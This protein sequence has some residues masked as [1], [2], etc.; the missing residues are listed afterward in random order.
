MKNNVAL[1]ALCSALVGVMC[2]SVNA[3]TPQ[4]K[5]DFNQSGR[6]ESGINEPGY[7]AWPIESA[8]SISK[9]LSGVTITLSKQGSNGSGLKSDWY[10]A[11]TEA[12]YYARLASDGVTVDGGEA[13]AAILMSFSGLPNGTHSLLLTLNTVASPTTNTFAP[14]DISVNGTQIINNLVPS[15]RATSNSAAKTA[16]I[17]FS[18]SNGKADILVKADTGTSASN[19]NVIINGF[20]LN[21]PD[22]TKQTA[23]PIP[24]D[25]DQHLDADNG[26]YTLRWTNAAG[27]SSQQVY[28]GTNKSQ[29]ES[30]TT[31]TS[32]IYKGQQIATSFAL[33]NLYSRNQYFWRV[34]S[35]DANGV[36]TRGNV[37]SFRP[38][39]L[40]FPGAEGYG[41]FAIGG[42]G[43]KV[44]KVTNLNDSGAGSLREAIE[45][46]SG[47]RTIVFD[48]AGII[49]LNSRLTLSHSFVT[50]AGQ[51]APGKGITVRGAPFGMSGAKD[52]VIQHIRVRLGAGP[53]FD[54]M[55]MAGSDHAIIDHSSVSWTIDEAF[56]SRGAK[57]ITLQR[58][59]L[60][61][62]LN[63][64]GHAN[65]PAGTAHG[66]AASIGGD[67]G[68]FHHNLLAHNEG[69][70]WSMA[71]GLDA[72]ANFAGRLDIFNN[73]VYNWGG[74]TTDGGASQV[75]FVNNYYKPGAASRV[76]HALKAD[77]EDNFGGKQQYYYSG[78]VMPGY[79]DESNSTKGR[80]MTGA[81]FSNY[82]PWVSQPFF[83]SYATI[84]TA[85]AA[86]KNVLSDVGATQPVFDNH[87]IRIVNETLNGTYTY[88]GSKS[89]KPGLPDHQNDVGGYES[90]PTTYRANDWDSDNDGLPNWWEVWHGLNVSSSSGDFSDANNDADRDGYT[91]LDKYL[92]WKANMHYNIAS[93]KTVSINLR[94]TFRGYTA[95]PNY[96]VSNVTNG[97]VA[98]S[99]TTATFTAKNCGMASFTL[100][101]KD[102]EGDSMNK[103]VNVFV[104]SVNPGMCVNNGTTSSTPSSS[105]KPASSST[106]SSATVLSSSSI[107]TSSSIKASSSTAIS[108]SLMRTSSSI[109]PVSSSKSSSSAASS[110]AIA[111]ST[112]AK[113][114]TYVVTNDWGSGFTGA[115]RITNTR[116]SVMNG[117][118]ISWTYSDSTRIT[119]SWNATV[120]GS[121]P[122]A[123]TNVD[124]N[125][126][127]QPGQTIEFGFQGTKA[128]GTTAIPVITGGACN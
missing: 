98:I 4:L 39:Q 18:T 121:N 126:V 78:N 19:K 57:N 75:N 91:Q 43:G 56:S 109:A 30:A 76:F 73:V 118:S 27:A 31:S 28:V 92:Q 90:Y 41:R 100:Q 25:N 116:T 59:M 112:G 49:T 8:A 44:V 10:K 3:Q 108:S 66:Y 42:R 119:N 48:V 7:I 2:Q 37:W 32:G 51:T 71:G 22:S 47:P 95:S 72:N 36:V 125:K 124:W 33:A 101:V 61:E 79:F 122:Y 40:A 21:I 80:T 65:Y 53:T 128:A 67:A 54:G 103:T 111:S 86:Y 34:D 74:R 97:S 107:K 113:N 85:K 6:P 89:G 114:C 64:A 9:T 105:S 120:T 87:D 20:G 55:G 102:S 23:N 38:R 63:I 62:A 83:P 110:S 94:D 82:E 13:G 115:I 17:T 117:W 96:S 14:L 81:P 46:D 50:V 1:H 88:K 12:P 29:V 16:Y 70:N 26:S 68:S 104:D 69:R 127:I 52:A 11:G 15:N 5:V 84:H 99:G 24:T 77:Y 60:A 35:V 45:T 58:V 106:S 123:A 93:G